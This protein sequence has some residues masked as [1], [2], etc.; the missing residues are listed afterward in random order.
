MKVVGAGDVFEF[1]KFLTLPHLCSQKESVYLD[2]DQ[3]ANYVESTLRILNWGGARDT[4]DL[5][6]PDVGSIVSDVNSCSSSMV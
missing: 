1:I 6:T 3:Y 2:D 4:S 5:R